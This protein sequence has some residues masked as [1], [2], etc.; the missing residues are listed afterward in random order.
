LLKRV[1]YGI[2]CR[3]YEAAEGVQRFLYF[4]LGQ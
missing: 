3:N 1:L 4:A 2:S